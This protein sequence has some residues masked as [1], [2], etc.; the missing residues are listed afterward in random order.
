MSVAGG[1]SLLV[2]VLIIILV[3]VVII[4]LLKFVFSI[5]AVL[6]MNG[7]VAPMLEPIKNFFL[8]S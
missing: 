5:F 2:Y 8:L 1:V 3:I 4:V 6:G 7:V